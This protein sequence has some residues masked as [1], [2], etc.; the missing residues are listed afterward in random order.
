MD[1]DIHSYGIIFNKS[2]FCEY[3]HNKLSILLI[4]L[5]FILCIMY[6]MQLIKTV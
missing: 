1:F 6:I 4:H 3:L 2:I 5:V